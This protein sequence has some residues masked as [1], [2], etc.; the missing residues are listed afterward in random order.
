MKNFIRTMK[1]FIN[2]EM[3]TYS[4]VVIGTMLL[5]AVTPFFFVYTIYLWGGQGLLLGVA[6]WTSLVVAFKIG[7]LAFVSILLGYV[8]GG[9]E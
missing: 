7:A 1:N 2:M 6:M 9:Y 8:V 3:V 4:L 5:V